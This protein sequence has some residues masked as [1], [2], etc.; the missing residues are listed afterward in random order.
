M[1]KYLLLPKFAQGVELIEAGELVAAV[2]EEPAGGMGLDH[3]LIGAALAPLAQREV[4]AEHE[5]QPVHAGDGL[6]EVVL[7][8]GP[9]LLEQS[10]GLDDSRGGLA[11]GFDRDGLD[12][13]AGRLHRERLLGEI[14]EDGRGY[15]ESPQEHRSPG[16]YR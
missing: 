13:E 16:E 1:L 5:R 8:V 9:A 14:R 7:V 3:Q 15:C 12:P 11:G 6:P 2:E 4:G 10:L